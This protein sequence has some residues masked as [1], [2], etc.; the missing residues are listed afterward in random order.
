MNLTISDR[1]SNSYSCKENNGYTVNIYNYVND[2]A[3]DSSKTFLFMHEFGHVTMLNSYPRSYDFT[4]LDY[5]TDNR[6]YLDEILPNYNTAWVEGWAN[7][8]AAANNNGMVFSYDL[9]SN[10][11]LAFLKDN[12]FD[13]MSRNE[14]FV[15][16]VLY[17]SFKDIKGG[18]AAAYDVFAKTSPHYSL[19]GFCQQ[20]V[21]MYPQNQVE[22]AKILIQN[23]YGRISLKELLTYINGGSYTVSKDLY[24]VL[25]DSGLLNGTATSNYAPKNTQT[26]SNTKPS[27]WDRIAGFFRKLFGKTETVS[28]PTATGSVVT[29]DEEVYSR[30]TDGTIAIRNSVSAPENG[31]HA[32]SCSVTVEGSA[33]VTFSDMSIADA[34]ELY[35][36]YFNE[37]NELMANPNANTQEIIEVQKRMIEAKDLL[38][39]LQGN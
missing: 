10:T 17:D 4:N 27:L 32:T 33:D 39:K 15:S 11:S 7:A 22:M 8:F 9:K 3:S 34:Q 2:F 18:Q 6:H 5:G 20:Y 30:Y 28:A 38:K 36:K 21:K 31:N 29:K 23:S 16:K 12:T 37:Y 24:A 19:E 26:A 35:Y 1:D 14:L 25:Q 13:E